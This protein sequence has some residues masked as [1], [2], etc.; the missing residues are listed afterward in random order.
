MLP[1]NADGAHTTTT[2]MNGTNRRSL[3]GLTIDRQAERHG[4]TDGREQNGTAEDGL[5]TKQSNASAEIPRPVSQGIQSG[6]SPRP[7]EGQ[8]QYALRVYL[9]LDRATTGSHNDEKVVRS[10][11]WAMPTD[12]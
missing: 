8:A 4:R 7:A 5:G 3:L 10:S 12:D 1:G 9:Y 2:T 6:A 11:V